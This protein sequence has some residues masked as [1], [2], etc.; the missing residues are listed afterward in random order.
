MLHLIVSGEGTS[1]LALG[2]I[3]FAFVATVLATAKLGQYLPKDVGRD[4]A[5]DGKLS[6]GKPR[7]AGIIFVLAFV[8]AAFLFAGLD[9][10][11]IIYLLLSK[12]IVEGVTLGGVKE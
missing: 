11:I 2:G 4:F 1:L 12:F 9:V 8:T 5:H 7:G 3:L 10:E 6:A